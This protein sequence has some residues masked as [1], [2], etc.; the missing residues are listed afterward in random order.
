M[1]C[2]IPAAGRSSRMGDW[3]PLLPCG[4]ST[5]IETVV[6]TALE[7]CRKVVLVVGYRGDELAGVFDFDDRVRIVR[8]PGWEAGMLSSIQEGVLQIDTK[9]FFIVPG[10]MPYLS[11]DVYRALGSA[12][13]A[14]A[15]APVYGG[16]RGHPVLIDSRLITA[17]TGAAPDIL[18]MRDILA[19]RRFTVIPWNDD[20]IL[21]DL[22]TPEEYRRGGAV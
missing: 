15:V 17:I 13:P 20:S 18:S 10:D 4:E 6:A 12:P 19:S 21:R 11:G 16:R 14:D 1:D 3:K 2:L 22:D 5:L 9:R 7:V 8:N